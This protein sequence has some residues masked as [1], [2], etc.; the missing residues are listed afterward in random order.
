MPA[1][2]L[3]QRLRADLK[4]AMQARASG[5]VALLRTLVAAIDNAE[6]VPI[7]ETRGME[8]QRAFGDPG[9]EVARRELDAAA[10]DALLADEIATRLASAATYEGHG[11]ADDAARL[12]A[13]AAIIAG[14]RTA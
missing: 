1:N 8:G 13:E 12:R 14:Y 9:A 11:R 5:E 7:E 2:E 10:L 3:K 6:A 4:A